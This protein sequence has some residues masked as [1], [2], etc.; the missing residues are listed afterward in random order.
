MS[1][2]SW[3]SPR[4]RRVYVLVVGVVGGVDVDRDMLRWWGGSLEGRVVV[5]LVVVMMGVM[6]EKML[7]RWSSRNTELRIYRVT[8][9]QCG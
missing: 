6:W 9:L 8:H 1:R 3:R 4:R 2:P 7:G 5:V